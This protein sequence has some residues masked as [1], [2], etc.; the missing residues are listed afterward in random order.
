MSLKFGKGIFVIEEHAAVL[1]LDVLLL[2]LFPLFPPMSRTLISAFAAVLLFSA[3]ALPT[4][5][6]LDTSA[7][8]KNLESIQSELDGGDNVG[9]LLEELEQ[10]AGADADAYLQARIGGKDVTLWDVPNTAWFFPHVRALIE[11]GVV[12]GYRNVDGDLTGLFGPAD[13]VTREQAL[14]IAL[15]AAGVAPD[16]P[17]PPASTKVSDWARPFASC[18]AQ[19][20]FGIAPGTDLTQPATRAETVHYLLRAFGVDAPEGNPPFADSATHTYK[21]DVAYAYAL[22]IVEGFKDVHG[23]LTGH[24]GPDENV[25]RAAMAKMAK[26]SIELL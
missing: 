4:F 11:L 5:A 15:G 13:T 3:S 22:G 7:L 21:N 17:A 23:N 10:A 16:C 24:F 9:D 12:A 8:E 2:S 1:P 26:L 20:N 14:K 18:A 6:F 25:N 19:M